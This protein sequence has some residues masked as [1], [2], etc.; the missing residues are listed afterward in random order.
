MINETQ[1][2][3]EHVGTRLSGYVDGELTQQERQ[4]VELHCEECSE[5]RNNLTE[6]RALRERIGNSSLS[7]VGED[8]WRETMH[9]STVQTTRS[10]GWL[11]LIAG[12]LVVFGIGLVAFLFSDEIGTGMK[13]LLVAIYGGLA[14]LFFSVIRQRFIEH[15]TDKYKDVEI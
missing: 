13:L 12:L 6:V 7:E 1:F 8:R 11:M 5:C 9:D 2:I 10:I 4:I 3:N 14:L 15:K